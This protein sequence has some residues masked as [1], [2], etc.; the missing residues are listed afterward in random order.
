MAIATISTTTAIPILTTQIQIK[1]EPISTNSNSKK[2]S[3]KSCK[4]LQ[5]IKQL[6][7]H[8]TK[9]GSLHSSSTL[10]KLIAKYAQ[11]G[12][13]ES[14]E[15]A[16]KAFEIFKDRNLVL[17]NTIL[18]NYVRLGKT[19]EALDIFCELLE[20]GPAPDRV[21]MLS[22]IAASAELGNLCFGRQCHAY[23][24]RNGLE[25]WDNIGNAIIDVYTKCGK[26]KWACRVFDRMSNK[27]IVSWNSLIAGFVR[28]G[29][30][31]EAVA[32]MDDN[33]FD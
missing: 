3:L 10:T 17:Y 11:V 33:G 16:Q 7:A 25:S 32:I 30:V 12:S 27:T 14:L 20:Q 2:W 21:T 24:L 5:E 23:V 4:N 22:A 29:D 18:S 26:Q 8:I 1:P 19:K 6:H 13:L 9:Q 15:Y 31:E 28:N